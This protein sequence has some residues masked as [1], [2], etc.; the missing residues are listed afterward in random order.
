MDDKIVTLKI[1]K[2]GCEYGVL[3]TIPKIYRYKFSKK[4]ITVSKTLSS[5]YGDI[6]AYYNYT[7]EE[8]DLIN[9]SNYM[10]NNANNKKVRN[11]D[12]KIEHIGGQVF[13]T[14]CTEYLDDNTINKTYICKIDDNITGKVEIQ[15]YGARFSGEYKMEDVREYIELLVKS[16]VEQGELEENVLDDEVDNNDKDSLIYLGIGVILLIIA[17]LIYIIKKDIWIISII[18]II[19]SM[20]F[21]LIYFWKQSKK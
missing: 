3:L 10:A 14:F 9:E 11:F 2:N 8:F 18:T 17:V 4:V 15:K 13:K 1:I 12:Y 20:I 5:K 6:V 21:V 16:R 7:T 19:I